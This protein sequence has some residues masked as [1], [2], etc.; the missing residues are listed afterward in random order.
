MKK[1]EFCKNLRD[2]LQ[3]AKATKKA[4]SLG[5]SAASGLEPYE[6][7]QDNKQ[8][9]PEDSEQHQGY[10]SNGNSFGGNGGNMNM[11]AAGGP[12]TRNRFQTAFDAPDPQR[13]R[14]ETAFEDPYAGGAN[15]GGT[16]NNS[17]NGGG[18]AHNGGGYAH[19][20]G[21]GGGGYAHGG[22]SGGNGSLNSFQ[23]LQPTW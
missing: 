6:C 21:G 23:N 2:N 8:P 5:R 12:D 18:Y 11:A 17:G 14:F 13:N 9:I 16:F 1:N 20:G 7:M 22:G 19:G 3:K 10:G 4:K 15:G